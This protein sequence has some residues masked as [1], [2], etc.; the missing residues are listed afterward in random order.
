[1]SASMAAAQFLRQR[2]GSKPIQLAVLLGTGLGPVAN[3]LDA[4]VAV[5]YRELPGFPLTSALDQAGQIT[6]GVE[7]GVRVAF[8]R[9]RT[10]WHEN[11]DA[12]TMV[13]PL[14]TMALLGAWTILR[15]ATA[16]SVRSGIYP[17]NIT[18]IT[19]HINVTGINPPAGTTVERRFVNLIDAHDPRLRLRLKRPLREPA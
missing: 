6:I 14:E 11:G 2:G 1:M 4:P 13:S 19:D 9:G 8:L 17:G 7:E 10:D 12:G 16:G 3:I 5:S 15:T 18:M